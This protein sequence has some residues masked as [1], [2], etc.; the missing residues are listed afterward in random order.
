M[1][2]LVW[3]ANKPA[4]HRVCRPPRP[5]AGRTAAATRRARG[6]GARSC[7]VGGSPA[8]GPA[9]NRA[10]RLPPVPAGGLDEAQGQPPAHGRATRTASWSR[11]V[12][13]SPASPPGAPGPIFRRGRERAPDAECARPSR[14]G[15]VPRPSAARRP[16]QTD[17]GFGLGEAGRVLAALPRPGPRAIAHSG[18]ES[19]GAARCPCPG[20]PGSRLAGLRRA[21]PARRV[22]RRRAASARG[23]PPGPVAGA[24]ASPGPRWA[25]TV[26]RR[27]TPSA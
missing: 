3:T 1:A 18:N 2:R 9:A 20:R 19:G 7:A 12:S 27:R 14:R 13:L 6:A 21:R 5:D 15:P 22:R 26:R 8:R 25:R 16:R 10:W 23:A 17:E 11:R 24:S 4:P